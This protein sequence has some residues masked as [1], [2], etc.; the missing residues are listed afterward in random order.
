MFGTSKNQQF[1]GVDIGESAVKLVQVSHAGKQPRLSHVAIEPL[2]GGLFVEGQI[3]DP[4]QIG[5][6]IQHILT[7]QGFTAKQAIACVNF[8][9]IISKRLMIQADLRGRE[10]EQWIEFEI[11]KFVPFPVSELNLD[12][13]FADE[14]ADGVERELLVTACRKQTIDKIQLC[15]EFAKLEPICIDV[16]HNALERASRLVTASMTDAGLQDLTAMVDVG[17]SSTRLYVYAADSLVYQREESFGARILVDHIAAEYSIGEDRALR[18]IYQKQLPPSYKTRVLKP[19]AKLMV[20]EIERSMLGFETAGVDGQISRVLLAG[21][22]ARVGGLP[23]IVEKRIQRDV[24][25]LD[26][27]SLLSIGKNLD[28][29]DVRSMAAQLA[30]ASGLALWSQNATL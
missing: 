27:L 10:L 28:A 24:S 13:E 11:D 8:S 20:K 17:T 9:D 7:E 30:L 15:L 2:P 4:E 6:L 22:S 23:R 21:G 5:T 25:V 3:V 29:N 18:S 16:A 1:I 26:A 19:Y 14:P 12:Y